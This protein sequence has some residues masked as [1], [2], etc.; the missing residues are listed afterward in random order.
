MSAPFTRL[1]VLIP[2]FNEAGTVEHIV[3]RV[4]LADSCGLEKEIILV[5]DASTDGTRADSAETGGT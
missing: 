1:S 2:V 4:R 3:E 5:D